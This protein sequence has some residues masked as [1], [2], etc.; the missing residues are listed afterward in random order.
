MNKNTLTAFVLMALVVFGFMAYEN[1][2]RREQIA[3]QLV[4]DSIA[5]VEAQNEA[6]VKL[7]EQ[8]KKA[9]EQADT[10]NPLFEV[11]KGTESTTV[12]ENE[13]LRVTLSNKGG[14]LKKVELKDN[15]YKSREGGNVVLFDGDDQN[16]NLMLDGKTANI[17]TDELFFTPTDVTKDGVTMHL[18]VASGSLDIAYSLK[19]NSYL[20]DMDVK[21]TGLEG[22]FPSKTKEM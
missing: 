19:P 20:L 21:A 18:P 15:T 12:I 10:L 2:A 11:R 4:L 7:K 8:Q 13:L 16:M 9:E 1:Y 6:K 22:F 5:Q 3:E 17:V 14:Q